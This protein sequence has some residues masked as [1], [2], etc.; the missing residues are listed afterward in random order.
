[1]LHYEWSLF[2]IN[3][4]STAYRGMYVNE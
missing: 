2:V 1:M 4:V 3:D